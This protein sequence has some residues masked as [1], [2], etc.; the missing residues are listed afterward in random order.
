MPIAATIKKA[1]M[2]KNR[3]TPLHSNN[4]M[5]HNKG[6]SHNGAVWWSGKSKTQ[7]MMAGESGINN[8]GIDTG[9]FCVVFCRFW[10]VLKP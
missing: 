7:L 4:G 5:S 6:S 8:L 10:F 2:G 9:L 3:A 1:R